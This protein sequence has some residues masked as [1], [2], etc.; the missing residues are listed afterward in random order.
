MNQVATLARERHFRD[1]NSAAEALRALVTEGAYGIFLPDAACHGAHAGALALPRDLEDAFVQL[2]SVGLPLLAQG[3]AREAKALRSKGRV[4]AAQLEVL[5]P[6]AAPG[7]F[8]W[9]ELLALLRSLGHATVP[10]SQLKKNGKTRLLQLSRLV[11]PDPGAGE[12]GGRPAPSVRLLTKGGKRR[13][14]VRLRAV[15]HQ[16]CQGVDSNQ[17][18]AA[19]AC[20]PAVFASLAQGL[21]M[22]PAGWQAAAV[23]A[24][25]VALSDGHCAVRAG[26]EK[27]DLLLCGNEL[28]LWTVSKNP[29]AVEACLHNTLKRTFAGLRLVPAASAPM[30]SPPTASGKGWPQIHSGQ[31]LMAAHRRS[32]S[33]RRGATPPVLAWADLDHL[34]GVDEQA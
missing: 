27:V 20:W 13:H 2:N 16:A 24:K 14:G 10:R 12:R 22:G 7:R 31:E 5:A 3:P 28:E 9:T 19:S 33:F 21:L 18:G 17:G 34:E 25:V 15:T 23:A 6:S 8:Q 11:L 32:N 1:W 30:L 4:S 26:R 29:S